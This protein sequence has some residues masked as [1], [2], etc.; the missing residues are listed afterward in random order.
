MSVSS[1]DDGLLPAWDEKGHIVADDGLTEHGT[2]EDVTD[3]S[4]GRFPHLLQLELLH[5]LLIGGDGGALDTNLVLLD[6]VSRL[7]C[8]LVVSG[9]TVL[10]GKIVVLE[11]NINIRSD[12]L[13]GG[14]YVS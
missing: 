13:Y 12:V 11:V 3:S 5:T 14:L 10:N 4:I 9:V 7:N 1:N 2:I 6:G 8:D